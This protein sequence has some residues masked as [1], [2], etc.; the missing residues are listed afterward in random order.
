M[1]C[2]RCPLLQSPLFP[3]AFPPTAATIVI[4]LSSF[5]VVAV[6]HRHYPLPRPPL[7][8]A[9]SVPLFPL[10]LSQ[11]PPRPLP[12]L[13]PPKNCSAGAAASLASHCLLPSVVAILTTAT[14]YCPLLTISQPSS[15]SLCHNRIYRS[16]LH[17]IVVT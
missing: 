8:P 15:S 16:H 10:L 6:T 3:M 17:P 7:P 5:P 11:P 2:R 13:P 14:R 9:T 4:F 1:A 12:S